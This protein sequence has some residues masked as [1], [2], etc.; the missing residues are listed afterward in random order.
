MKT[1]LK[2]MTIGLLIVCLGCSD[3]LD[4]RPRTEMKEE[5]MYATEE[6]FKNVLIGAYIRLASA[7]LYGKNVTVSVPELL[8]QHWETTT[9]TEEAKILDDIRKFNFE[10]SGAKDIVA[11][12]WLQYY[13]TI[14][15]LN[16]MLARIDTKKDIFTKGNY[17]L[18]KGEA[19]GLR[20][21]L[22]FDILRL[23]G[24]VPKDVDMGKSA[25]PYLTEMTKD[26]NKALPLSYQQVLENIRIDLDG[27][28]KLLEK[29]PIIECRPSV[30]NLGYGAILSGDFKRPE[31][32]FQYYRSNRFNYYA[33]KATKARYY[34]WID[35]PEKAVQY[36][37]EVITAVNPDDNTVKFPLADVVTDGT[38]DNEN[39]DRIMSCEH[40]FALH[41][42]MLEEIIR[43]LFIDFGGYTQKLNFIQTAYETA[44]HTNDIRFNKN[45]YWEEKPIPVSGRVQNMF[46]KYWVNETT[47]TTLMPLIRV[48]E[49]YFIVMECGSITEAREKFKSFRISRN[50]DSSVDNELNDKTAVDRRLEKEYRKEFYGEGQMFYYYK[51]HQVE[52]YTWPAA[53][54]V[55]AAKYIIPRP[56]A[57]LV[58]E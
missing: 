15:S 33:V 51:R 12:M 22:H 55:N 58:F 34:Q 20:A 40:I 1:I 8:A 11:A 49:M 47:S 23:W 57:Q 42:S 44:I 35:Q 38:E 6:G 28:E 25:I 41:S 37:N 29:D 53:F 50:M 2:Y 13:K 32:E 46:K 39:G 54:S 31:D 36:A 9:S 19:L 3:W 24:P 5:D 27:A 16:N 7:D 4:V 43:P 10:N 56:D 30:L 17:E 52:Q 48:S 21:F 26:P 45:N 18:I 14:A